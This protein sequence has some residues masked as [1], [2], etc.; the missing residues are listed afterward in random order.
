MPHS[1]FACGLVGTIAHSQD[2]HF[3]IQ[4]MDMFFASPN[5]NSSFLTLLPPRAR[6]ITSSRFTRILRPSLVLIDRA[7]SSGVGRGVRLTLSLAAI[8]AYTP[9][10]SRIFIIADVLMY[11]RTPCKDRTEGE[12]SINIR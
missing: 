10:L 4:D 12:S 5:R 3:G 9:R 6:L 1:L 8:S 11:S 7:C 2:L